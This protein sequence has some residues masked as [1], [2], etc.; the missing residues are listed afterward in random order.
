MRLEALGM[1]IQK[2]SR[3]IPLASCLIIAACGFR[4]MYAESAK[5]DATPSTIFAGV[6]IDPI[7]GGG[8]MGQQF[9]INLEDRLNPGGTVPPNPAYRLSA[10]LRSRPQAIGIARDGTVSRYN[11]YL[12][13]EYALYRLADGEKITSGKVRHVSSYNNL[14]NIYFSTYISE[15]DAIRRGVEELSEIYRARLG[16]YLDEG[17]PH[18]QTVKELPAP[19]P[20]PSPHPFEEGEATALPLPKIP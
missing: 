3:L 12:D 19:D 17:A 9:R 4:P 2:F 14:T 20:I 13:S 1:S 8:R 16:A 11:V 15:Q 6:R 5:S 10:T 7:P 18:R